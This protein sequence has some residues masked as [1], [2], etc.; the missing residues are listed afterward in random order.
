MRWGALRKEKRVMEL[1][2]SGSASKSYCSSGLEW[3]VKRNCW[4]DCGFPGEC[5]GFRRWLRREKG[6]FE[7]VDGFGGRAGKGGREGEVV[8]G[9]EEEELLLRREMVQRF[10]D[11][12]ESSSS[13]STSSS[14]SDEFDES[15]G[16][17]FEDAVLEGDEDKD[18]RE[19]EE[20][21]RQSGEGLRIEVDERRYVDEKRDGESDITMRDPDADVGAGINGA[22][23]Y[24]SDFDILRMID[25]MLKMGFS[26]SPPSSPLKEEVCYD[27]P[28][29]SEREPSEPMSLSRAK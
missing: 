6:R 4:V 15:E 5:G 17:G 3:M 21:R 26:E 9:Q 19:V 14:S 28:E 23:E 13:S 7:G 16:S 22:T 20:I 11:G 2:G 18:A 25:G 1:P 12:D 10:F 8:G 29:R 24:P 27:W